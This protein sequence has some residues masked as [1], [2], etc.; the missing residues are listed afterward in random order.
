MSELSRDEIK[1]LA[2]DETIYLRGVRYYKNQA[3]T[4]V[5]WSKANKQYHAVVK[6]SNDY[7]VMVEIGEDGVT[8]H[9]CNCP[10]HAKYPGACKH[11]V[12][13]LLFISDYLERKKTKAPGNSEDMAA[14]K[15]VQYFEKQ[16]YG[17]TY[18]DFYEIEVHIRI[19]SLLR[20]NDSKVYISLKAGANRMY[21]IQNIRK[22]LY[23][24][25]HKETIVLGKE[26]KF[27]YG[28][29]TFTK[30]SQMVLDYLLEIYEIHDVLGGSALNNL[31][32]KTHM[33][34][35]K[36]MLLTLLHRLNQMHFQMEVYGQEYEKVQF[37]KGN[38]VIK[39]GVDMVDD[40]LTIED[41]QEEAI[42]PL[43]DKGQL[44]LVGDVLYEP[45]RHFIKNYV[46][47]YSFFG[48]QEKVLNFQNEI[49]D[50]FMESVLPKIYETMELDVTEQLKD[51]FI[52]SDVKASIFLDKHKQ[53]VRATVKFQYGDYTVNPLDYVAK[54]GIIIVRQPEKENEIIY[55]LEDMHFVPS[56]N[57]Y[58]LRDERYIFDFL[59]EGIHKLTSICELFY[60]DDF[61][62]MTMK[63]PGKLTTN[64]KVNNEINMLEVEMNYDEIPK[65]ELRELF[66]A[67]QLKK[68]YHRLK[69]GNFIP[70][71]NEH[72]HEVSNLLDHLE[73]EEDNIREDGIVLPKN[74]ALY[75]SNI[76]EEKDYI[77]VNKEDD[78]IDLVNNILDPDN[79][80]FA[81]PANLTVDLRPYQVTG[82]KWL[83][84]LARNGL[85]GILADDMGL[86]KTLQTIVYIV[87]CVL[88]EKEK[89]ANGDKDA[90]IGPHLIVCPTSLVYNWQDE[91][92]N[93]APFIKTV[94]VS[95]PP[96]LRK[97]LIESKDQVDVIITSYP[98]IRRDIEH[99]EKLSIHTM[100][101]DEAQFIKNANSISAKAV[102]RIPA[103]HRFALTGTPIE[104]SLSELWSIFDFV[105]PYYLYT[106]SKFVERYEKPIIK[107]ENKEALA[108]LGKHI[109]PFI[110]R[111]MKK[112]VLEELPE[113]IETKFL[114]DLTEE[115]KKIY[116]S[117][118]ESIRNELNLEIEKNGI[119]R[120]QI[121]ILAALTRLRQICCHPATFIENY[122]GGSGKLELLMDIIPDILLN[123]HR[124][125]IF[126]QFTSMLQLIAKE[127]Q[128]QGIQYFYLEGSTAMEDR[129]DYVRRF[130]SGEGEV[131][132]ISLKAGGT[133]LNLTGADTVIHFDPWWNPAVEEQ[134]T[135]RVYRIG[136]K[137]KVQVIKLLTKG[138]IEEK[139]YKLQQKKKALSEAVIQSKEV[140]INKLTRE[141]IEDLFR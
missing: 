67:I 69:N 1:K 109:Q 39:L 24:Y 81:V 27:I 111:R 57:Y 132:L 54:D 136:Q 8:K 117:Y 77:A 106:H 68:K 92:G 22:F 110:L 114:T 64:L 75:I 127:L 33:V 26:F 50:K 49:K 130:N 20:E 40:I 43:T 28:E 89:V 48:K 115:Q 56:R 42:L 91:F 79:G 113:K 46:P 133:G 72:F 71:D 21:K 45:D 94:V 44:M 6:G 101:I 112:D 73:V 99:Y 37:I 61:K 88:T 104:N 107:E 9:H 7:N 137:N 85:G 3:V 60:S 16:D 53:N 41:K 13:M 31:F 66:H 102:K 15:I 95:G 108:D 116:L 59:T 83:R 52:V 139:I 11:V 55:A 14:Y 96:E 131:F 118:M 122:D 63:T 5:K 74:T 82:Y 93:F 126:S 119:E 125:L 17:I 86:G 35:T 100:I 25:I 36:N 140:F 135:D 51:K 123:G 103:K 34:I 32:Q 84:T 65:E 138:T 97:E 12:A 38:P 105:M 120:S 121:K 141:E 23:D 80:Q 30:E 47:F 134:A 29:S 124:I 70:L 128:A 76:L 78:F 18:G 4:N 87:S 62:N 10:G 98:L 129:G 58:A 2:T 90:H 19:P